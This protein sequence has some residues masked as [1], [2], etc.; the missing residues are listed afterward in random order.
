MPVTR[1]LRWWHLNGVRAWQRMGVNAAGVAGVATPPP[2]IWPAGVVLCWQ[3]P[4]FWQVFYF[5]PSAELLN[6]ASRCHFHLQCAQCIP[7]LIQQ[8]NMNLKN[9]PRMH[10]ITPFWDEKFINFLGRGT[11]PPQ[12]LA[13]SPPTAPR[14]LR[15]R[16]STCDPQCSSGVDAHAWQDVYRNSDF[17][18][19]FQMQPSNGYGIVLFP[20][21]TQMLVITA[22]PWSQQ[23]EK[24]LENAWQG[25]A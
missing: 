15:L 5:L 18:L 25:L 7:F 13:L 22:S 6:T 12:T 20:N 23:N 19:R 17:W 16:R 11:A 1:S 24:Q 21:K 9:T 3:P 2:N 4:I 8:L 14:F 10:R